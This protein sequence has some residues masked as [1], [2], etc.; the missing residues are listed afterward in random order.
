MRQLK[1]NKNCLQC[2][3]AI[4]NAT[5][6]AKS[7]PLDGPFLRSKDEPKTRPN[8]AKKKKEKLDQTLQK[9]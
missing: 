9:R 3:M 5:A 8:I 4:G 2:K 1:F 6:I 7:S